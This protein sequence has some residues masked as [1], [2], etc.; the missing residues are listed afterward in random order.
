MSKLHTEKRIKAVDTTQAENNPSNFEDG[1]IVY[2]E[3]GGGGFEGGVEKARP[4]TQLAHGVD[5]ILHER[6]QWRNHNAA[7]G[8]RQSRDLIAQRFAA[9]GG[10]QHQ[11]I[12]ATGNLINDIGLLTTEFT[13]AKH[14]SQLLQSLL[15]HGS[16]L[17]VHG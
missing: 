1:D 11:G 3:D 13:V 7:T 17:L 6:N 9:A 2:D 5:L 14:V 4:H 16:P 15:A 12:T 8:S 10:H